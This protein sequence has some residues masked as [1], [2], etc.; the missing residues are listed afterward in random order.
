M[1]LDIKRFFNDELPAALTRNADEAKAIGARYQINIINE[2]EWHVD[3]TPTGPSC[4]E[5]SAEADCTMTIAAKEFW[6]AL[7]NPRVNGPALFFQRKLRVQ[8][9]SMVAVKLERLFS[10]K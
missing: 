9:D 4:V 3:C 1:T 6:I 5:G 2:G 8:G 7:E 10:F